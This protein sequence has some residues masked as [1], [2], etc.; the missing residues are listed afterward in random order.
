MLNNPI[1]VLA[2][3]L[4]RNDLSWKMLPDEEK[5]LVLSENRK[6]NVNREDYADPE[7][8]GQGRHTG[9]E[10][11]DS[12]QFNPEDT[13]GRELLSL[14]RENNPESILEIGPGAGFYSRLICTYQSVTKYTAVDIGTAFLEYLRPRLKE[15]KESKNLDYSLVCGE[16]TD[17]AIPGK[18]D[19]IVLLSTVH[20]IPNRV[21]L[22][23]RLN[24]F[25]KEGGIIFCA[26]PSHYL[27]RIAMLAY[28][29][30][31]KGYMKKEFLNDKSNF[32]TH[33]MCTYG[34]YR[35]IFERIPGL[36]MERIYFSLPGK[37]RRLKSFSFS[38]KWLSSEIGIVIRKQEMS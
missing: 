32:S 27:Y 34:E 11:W 23:R 4:L 30:L 37:L 24:T 26:D 3:Y 33:H 38:K 5:E 28:K 17:A 6:H 2:Y 20:H 14:L 13:R 1:G 16:I 22:F 31:F 10:N 18:Y 25:L 15:F 12:F 7:M 9:G 29:C 8:Y 19:M 36:Q 21:D 35:R